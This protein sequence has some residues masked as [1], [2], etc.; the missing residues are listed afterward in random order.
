MMNNNP[1]FLMA[2]PSL[3]IAIGSLIYL[4]GNKA[5]RSTVVSGWKSFTTCVVVPG[6]LFLLLYFSLAVHMHK[7]LGKWPERIGNHGFSSTLNA[8]DAVVSHYF[9]WFI[10]FA[11]LAWPVLVASFAIIARL[12]RYL[13]Q[14]MAL[15]L[16]FW[17]F[18]P[19]MFLA[20]SDFLNW[21][22]D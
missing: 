8:H 16:S 9:S 3:L 7:S 13:P 6:L 4:C 18:V 17:L 19:L 14:V 22:W 2:I 20:P 1:G 12:N 21:W 10:I 5:T 15:G 11:I